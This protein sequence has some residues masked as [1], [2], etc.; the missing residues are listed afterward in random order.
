MVLKSGN[1]HKK[2]G[3]FLCFVFLLQNDGEKESFCRQVSQYVF[4]QKTEWSLFD[5]CFSL[6][7]KK[8]FK[9]CAG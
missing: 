4:F 1:K 2:R 3:K 5:F 6:C 8:F 7:I 9:I